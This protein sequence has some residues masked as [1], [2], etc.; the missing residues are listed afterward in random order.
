MKTGFFLQIKL[1][2]DIIAFVE[3]H[4]AIHTRFGMDDL[5]F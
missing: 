4:K 3:K 5:F 1:F 2:S